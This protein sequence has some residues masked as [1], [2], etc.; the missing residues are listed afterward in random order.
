MDRLRLTAQ[1][2][3]SLAEVKT[4][5]YRAGADGEYTSQEIAEIIP[6]LDYAYYL[7]EEAEG[8]QAIH[9]YQQKHGV[10]A[11]LDRHNREKVVSLWEY[12]QRKAKREADEGNYPPAA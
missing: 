6:K 5:L 4:L 3:L 8:V 1:T 12:R 2:C 11:T 7:A 9:E 10:M